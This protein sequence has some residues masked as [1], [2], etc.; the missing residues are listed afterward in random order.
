MYTELIKERDALPALNVYAA[1][2]NN[3]SA[4]TTVV[5]MSLF[6]RVNFFGLVSGGVAGNNLSINIQQTN[7]ANGSSPTNLSLVTG[8][9]GTSLAIANQTSCGSFSL[10]ASATQFTARYALCN[11]TE[12]SSKAVT[13]SC[14]AVATE[15]RYKPANTNDN[16]TV[17]S[18]VFAANS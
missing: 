6:N 15:A 16:S 7:N 10:E 3:S 9:T 5:D 2:L 13:V 4:N 17:I 18:R 14:L 8:I 12:T 1:T 11:M